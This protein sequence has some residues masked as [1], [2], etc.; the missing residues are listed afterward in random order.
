MPPASMKRLSTLTGLLLVLACRPAD[1]VVITSFAV[2]PA[3][4]D[5][6]DSTTLTWSSTGT[7]CSIGPDGAV[8]DGSGSVTRSPTSD[9]VYTLT[10][11][12]ASTTKSVSV[13]GPVR[14]DS[15]TAE[16]AAAVAGGMVTLSW[17]APNARGCT[18]TPGGAT[19]G[20]QGSAD[21]TVTQETE[22]TLTCTGGM[23]PAVK[24][25]TVPLASTSN[26]SL[27][28]SEGTLTLTW[29][30]Q[31]GDSN[32]YL[33]AQS[34]IT[35]TN[36]GSLTA[37][38]KYLL[39]KSPVVLHGLVAGTTYY[40]RV[41]T[42]TE[43]AEGALSNEASG[44]VPANSTG[45][46]PL[47]NAQWFLSN[48]GQQGGTAG[49]DIHQEGALAQNVNGAGIRVAVVDEG[50]DIDHEDLKLNHA[51]L[52]DYDYIDGATVDLAEHGTCVAGLALERGFNGIGGRGV[53]PFANFVS[54]NI[55]QDLTSANE[56][57]A[58]TRGKA[59]NHVSSNSWGDADDNTGLLS[60]ADPDW[61]RGVKEGTETG[62]GGKGTVYV[63]AA[64]NGADGMYVDDSNFDGQA[65][66]RYVLAIAGVGDDGVQVYY[67]EAGANVLVAAP[68]GGRA[69]HAL[70]TTDITGTDGYNDGNTQGEIS[71]PNYTQTMDGTSAS[72]PVVSGTVALILQANPALTWRDVRRVLAMSARKNDAAD[73]DWSLNGAGLHVNHKY[74][75]GVVDADAA[76]RLA[77]TFT[78][79]AIEKNFSSAVSSP[80]T[81]IPDNNAT[82]ISNAITVNNSGVGHVEYVEAIVTITHPRSGDLTVTLEKTGGTHSVLHPQHR[83]I[84]DSHNTETCSDIDQFIFGSTRHLDE[85]GDGVWTLKVKDGRA[86]KTGSLV[87]WQLKLY[88]R[89]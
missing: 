32:L 77:K 11:G 83:C 81:A 58:M 65:N 39:V 73:A 3:T 62:R 13:R 70:T 41:A 12:N 53:A 1:E 18:V 48:F 79:G 52:L 38:V 37:G 34:G 4:I 67:S 56:Y 80:G 55:L 45:S 84:P 35:A 29:D 61:L 64:G 24:K 10:C 86:S 63:W 54:Y 82:G 17:V 42:A 19:G 71:N 14:I 6:G 20:A 9:T 50:V 33:A 16:P 43:T 7:S 68:T 8:V 46:D 89:P 22:Y 27:V 57:D 66:S 2:S 72:T 26:L 85:P 74:G 87:S 31:A 44:T 49:E 40:A 23:G 5:I 36:I 25:L 76:V 15:F 47:Y 30:Q 59:T 28:G 21:V 75:F 51:S 69:D 60:E 88:G 78:A